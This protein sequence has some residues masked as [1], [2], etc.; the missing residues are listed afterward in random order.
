MQLS[1]SPTSQNTSGKKG[2]DPSLMEQSTVLIPVHVPAAPHSSD[3]KGV[4]RNLAVPTWCSKNNSNTEAE[5][6]AATLEFIS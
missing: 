4:S 3:S 2:Q 5:I 6:K 1:P